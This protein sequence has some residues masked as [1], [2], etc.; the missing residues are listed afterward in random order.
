MLIKQTSAVTTTVLGEIKIVG[1]MVLSALLLGEGKQFTVKMTV[2]CVLA[3]VGFCMYSHTK[4]VAFR[5]KDLVKVEGSEE[6]LA[7]LQMMQAGSA[8]SRAASPK[9]PNED[10]V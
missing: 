6:E 1:L 9:M 4:I 7:P 2:G 10:T 5:S 8:A 3:S